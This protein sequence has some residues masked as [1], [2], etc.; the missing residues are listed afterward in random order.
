LACLNARGVREGAP[1]FEQAIACDPGYALAYVGLA[2]C[3]LA[4]AAAGLLPHSEALPRATSILARAIALDDGLAQAWTL[5]G[6][7]RFSGWECGAAHEAIARALEISPRHAHAHSARA[8]TLMLEGRHR[9]AIAPAA[10]A[11]EEDPLA[12]LWSYQLMMVQVW[13]SDCGAAD[14]R[15][16]IAL[17]FDAGNW[18]AHYI[19]GLVGVARGEF[20]AAARAFELAAACSGQAP[21]AVSGCIYARARAGEGVRAERELAELLDRSSRMFVPAL[22]VAT[23]YLGTGDRHQAFEWLE[24][25]YAERDIWLRTAWWNPLFG[26]LRT[27]P[28]MVD[29]L[30][31]MDLVDAATADGTLGAALGG[32]RS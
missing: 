5:L 17:Q 31:R 10:R 6:V 30:R 26:E 23:A 27:D 20:R 28:R 1:Y 25:S 15:A 3:D 13:S 24:R 32:V 4:S 21:Q 29:L 7:A 18:T 12:Q 2:D 22:T 11:V 14:E 8:T 19:Q 9:E 16:R